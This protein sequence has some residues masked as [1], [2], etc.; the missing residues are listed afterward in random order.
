MQTGCALYL[1]LKYWEWYYRT[2]ILLIKCFVVKIKYPFYSQAC[3]P[4]ISMVTAF[5]EKPVCVKSRWKKEKEKKLLIYMTKP[6]SDYWVGHKVHAGFPK[7]T[8]W[9]ARTKSKVVFD[10]AVIDCFSESVT[11]N[12][13]QSSHHVL[14]P[15]HCIRSARTSV[16]D[17]GDSSLLQKTCLS[18][19]FVC[20][21][22]WH[23]AV[24]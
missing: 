2:G 16:R 15:N 8:F 22:A 17:S 4:L 12:L 14:P 7:W 19:A 24:V 21:R 6:N 18:L 10:S 11:I 9:P 20:T 13:P 1:W 5:L 23:S 3:R